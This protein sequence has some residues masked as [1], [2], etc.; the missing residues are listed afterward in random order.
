MR[1]PDFQ[2]RSEMRFGNRINQSRQLRRIVPTRRSHIAFAIGLWG[3]DFDTLIPS[4]V[5]DSSRFLAKMPRGSLASGPPRVHDTAAGRLHD[6]VQSQE[7]SH[8]QLSHVQLLL[9]K[10][11]MGASNVI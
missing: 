7:G 6:A 5:I 11:L 9:Y 4:L 2:H 10:G 1:R 8:N 3:G